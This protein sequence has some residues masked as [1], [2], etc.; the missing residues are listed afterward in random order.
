MRNKNKYCNF[1]HFLFKIFF[2]HSSD[3]LPKKDKIVVAKTVSRS[4]AGGDSDNFTGIHMVV[5]SLPASYLLGADN[6]DIRYAL[7]V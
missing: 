7:R 4:I 1:N 6:I 5:P 3:T 2:F